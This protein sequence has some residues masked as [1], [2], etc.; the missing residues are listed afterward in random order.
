MGPFAATITAYLN[1]LNFDGDDRR[2]QFWGLMFGLATIVGAL[3]LVGAAR[4]DIAAPFVAGWTEL[5]DLFRTRTIP[6]EVPAWVSPS[7]V[8]LTVFA[9]ASVVTLV[10]ATVRRLRDAGKPKKLWLLWFLPGPGT[11]ALAWC[12]ARPSVNALPKTDNGAAYRAPGRGWF[13][14]RRAR[15]VRG[16]FQNRMAFRKRQAAR[17]RAEAAKINPFSA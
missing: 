17:E 2:D 13:G 7:F 1:A 5:I 14:K 16:V 3:L 10:S 6:D 8:G 12:L 9:L 11:L 15:D 4:P